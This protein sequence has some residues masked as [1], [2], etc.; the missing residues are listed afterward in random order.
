MFMVLL[1]VYIGDRIVFKIA[2]ATCIY[3]TTKTSPEQEL[4]IYLQAWGYYWQ[5]VYL[6]ENTREETGLRGAK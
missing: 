4:S 6:L 1:L 5:Q 3:D 2:Q